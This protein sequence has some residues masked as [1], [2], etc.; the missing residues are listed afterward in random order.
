MARTHKDKNLKTQPPSNP[1]RPSTITGQ[2]STY[3]CSAAN[4]PAPPTP[5]PTDRPGATDRPDPAPTPAGDSVP[6]VQ[7]LH[8]CK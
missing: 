3:A 2:M 5:T 4:A 7:Y 8:A 1:V 6:N